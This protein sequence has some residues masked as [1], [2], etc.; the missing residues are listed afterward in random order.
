MDNLTL[1]CGG[2]F[3]ISLAV[4]VWLFGSYGSAIVTAGAVTLGYYAT[5]RKAPVQAEQKA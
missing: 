4:L 3:L 5:V 2:I 1:K